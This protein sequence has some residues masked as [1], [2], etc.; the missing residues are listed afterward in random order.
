MVTIG[1]TYSKIL[2]VLKANAVS[3]ITR[4]TT[5]TIVVPAKHNGRLKEIRA[6]ALGTI[7]T[8]VNAGGL[9]EIE[10]DAI[11]IDCSFVI[12]GFT[13]VT[14][15]GG[16]ENKAEVFKVDYPQ[17]ENSTYT[18][19]YTPYD[20]QSQTL[21]IE[22]VWIVTGSPYT[23]ADPKRANYMKANMVLKASAIT[24][25]TV[26][27]DHNTISIP[28]GKGGTLLE[29]QVVVFP[30]TE[31][32]VNAGGKCVLDS[33]ADDWKPFELIVGGITALGGSGGGQIRADK[34]PCKK[35]ISG[36]N[37]VRNDFTPYDNQSQ[38]L[39]LTLL[40]RGPDPK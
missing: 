29:V 20:D 23:G 26:A 18:I 6:T 13:A 38:S 3:A 37:T 2:Y 34:R 24:Q 30:T 14:E 12:G 8:V 11:K 16:G 35:T 17:K 15:G 5:G 39:G 7:E 22:L 40:W 4:A 27:E 36:N 25:I 33:D 1:E 10:N 31:T 9:V 21:E 19:Y 28:S 32:V